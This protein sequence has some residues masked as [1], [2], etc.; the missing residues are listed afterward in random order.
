MPKAYRVTTYRA[1][2]LWLLMTVQPTKLH[3]PLSMTAQIAT[4]ESL[5]VHRGLHPTRQ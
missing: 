2:K 5:Q 1:V 4:S 3:W